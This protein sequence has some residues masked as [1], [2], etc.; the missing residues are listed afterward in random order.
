VRV[1]RPFVMPE[2]SWPWSL[3]TRTTLILNLLVSAA[4]A[5]AVYLINS[6]KSPLVIIQGVSDWRY[7]NHLD[8]VRAADILAVSVAWFAVLIVAALIHIWTR[9]ANE[10]ASIV[11]SVGSGL[12]VTLYILL[13][14]ILL[15]PTNLVQ[16]VIGV[17]TFGVMLTALYSATAS[18]APNR[19]WGFVVVG[20]TGTALICNLVDA[21]L[22]FALFCC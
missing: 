7:K 15:D 12:L 22:G 2:R 20:F 8:A 9:R 3:T 16:D 18:L 21:L 19:F 4:F 11:D 5:L 13:S 17:A 14:P 6:A 1:T 10:G